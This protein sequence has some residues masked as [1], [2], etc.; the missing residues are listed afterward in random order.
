MDS[1]HSFIFEQA[2]R[3]ADILVEM[4]G[5]RCEV[6]VHDFSHLEQ[7]M[8][9]LAGT[10]TNRKIGAPITDLVLR[11]LKKPAAEIKD[12]PNYTTTTKKG[13][14]MKS[15]TV[16]LRD[17]ES[18]IIGALCINY[19]INLM[20]QLAGE[21]QDFIPS[22]EEQNN[23][24]N[25]FSTIHDVIESMVKQVSQGFKRVPATLDMEEKI[26]F[27]RRLEEKGTFLIKGATEYVASVL[28]VSKFTIYNYLHKI[29]AQNE[30][31]FEEAND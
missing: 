22:D 19:D 8:I 12:I 26:E 7:S 14:I 25:F 31:H 16:F 21:I 27:V 17:T 30:Y 20:I 28:N 15:S 4:F 18:N 11:E 13:I 29:R 6:A 5:P 10:V 9:H 23:N 2:I 3:T 24:E 1:G